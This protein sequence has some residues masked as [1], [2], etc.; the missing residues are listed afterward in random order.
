MRQVTTVSGMQ[1]LA[2]RWKAEGQGI[3]FVPTM[4]YLHAGHL[5][6]V[7]K[8]RQCAGDDGKVVVSIYVNPLQFGA[9]E[10]LSRY[11]RDLARDQKLCLE[12]GVDLLFIPTDLEMYPEASST[13]GSHSTYVIEDTLSRRWE[14]AARPGHFRGVATVVAKLLNQ[15]LPDYAVFGAK[16][17]QQAAIVQRLVRD[18][19][20][21]VKIV[22]APT[23]RE[24]DG[25]A[26]S[27]RNKYLSEEERLQATILWQ[28]IQQAKK[29]VQTAAAPIPADTLKQQLLQ[30]IQSQPAARVDYV[31]FFNPATLEPVAQAQHGTQL[32]LA[33]FVGKTRLIDNAGL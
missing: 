5:S 16:D 30:L 10:D 18:L 26:M 6:L 2:R 12:A 11:P 17:F 27:S 1:R 20:F 15:V 31:D 28:A 29:A 33:V 22:V 21:P 14:G 25:L 7:E 3:G 9:Q 4:G 13:G 8:A 32:A 19:N 23:L 24:P